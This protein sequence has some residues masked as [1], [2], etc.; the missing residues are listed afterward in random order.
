[1]ESIRR[2]D[3]GTRVVV[4]AGAALALASL[5]HHAAEAAALGSIR[6]PFVALL[7]DGVPSLLLAYAGY[8]LGETELGPEYRW[9][10]AVWCLGGL[11]VFTGV[12]GLTILVRLIEG[13]AV[14]EAWFTLLVT[15]SAG[16]VAG[17]VAGYYRARALADASRARRASETLAFVNDLVRH[18]LRNDMQVIRAYAAEL[19]LPIQRSTGS[20]P[21]TPRPSARRPTRRSNASSRRGRSRRPSPARQTTNRSTWPRSPTT[22]PPRPRRRPTSPSGR[23]CPTAP[24][25][26]PTPA[27]AR[28]STTSSRTRSST[29]RRALVRRLTRTPWNTVPRALVRRLTRTPWNTVPRAL[30]RRL[31]R[32]PWN[33]VPRALA[34]TLARTRSSTAR[35]ALVR[36]PAR[37]RT[38]RA[39]P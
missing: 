22:W 12:L 13:R 23:T 7:L 20:W 1:M 29:A 9:L 27:S 17:V 35:R 3:A 31:T 33:T 38:N 30:V 24:P 18:D 8:R 19:R 6:G 5:A 4:G 26:S 36:R 15:A 39:S 14:A 21:T 28:S 16:G 10:A 32:T 2:W 11:V 25:S 37:T 34:P